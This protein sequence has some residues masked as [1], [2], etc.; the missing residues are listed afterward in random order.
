MRI[1]S[2]FARPR[3]PFL[4]CCRSLHPCEDWRRNIRQSVGSVTISILNP[5]P[6]VLSVFPSF[7]RVCAEHN[8]ISLPLSVQENG[9]ASPGLVIMVF[10]A[11]SRQAIAVNDP[12]Y[13][14]KL[15]VRG[16]LTLILFIPLGCLAWVATFPSKFQSPAFQ[17]DTNTWSCLPLVRNLC[18]EG[19]RWSRH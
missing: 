19:F 8:A 9:I 11:A 1:V 14:V 5:L 15:R 16:A 12:S 6:S 18:P 7:G 2:Q 17:I 3:E 10:T 13:L 4:P